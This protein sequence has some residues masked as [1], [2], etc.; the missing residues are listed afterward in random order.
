M[1]DLNQDEPIFF[2]ELADEAKK[3]SSRKNSSNV[4][5]PSSI[6]YGASDDPDPNLQIISNQNKLS[7]ALMNHSMNA[8]FQNSMIVDSRRTSEALLMQPRSSIINFFGAQRGKQAQ[9]MH[10]SIINQSRGKNA[11][12]NVSHGV[13]G[14]FNLFDAPLAR[15]GSYKSRDGTLKYK[16]SNIKGKQSIAGLSSQAPYDSEDDDK[17]PVY[18][19]PI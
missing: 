8:K 15:R 4:A 14:P 7:M 13:D 12:Q 9:A 18:E 1:D 3:E 11:L 2:R 10:A 17:P 5:Q 16:S 6:Q 19:L